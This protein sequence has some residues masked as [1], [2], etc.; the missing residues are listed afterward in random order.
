MTLDCVEL[1]LARAFES[2]QAY[3]ALSRTRSL[4][5]L[6]VKD[7]DPACVRAHPEALEY[8]RELRRVHRT[9]LN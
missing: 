8:Y 7:F 3:V 4:Q 1:S 6:R 5:A 2:G 9:T